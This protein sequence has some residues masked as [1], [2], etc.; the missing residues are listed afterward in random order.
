MSEPYVDLEQVQ[1]AEAYAAK[2]IQ[3][4]L[5]S[6]SFKRC[7]QAT[8]NRI[9]KEWENAPSPLERE[10]ARHKLDA[11]KILVTELRSYGDRPHLTQA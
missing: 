6:D 7:Q 4:L 5:K 10:M 8:R 1:E 2:E 9:V 11:F 3:H